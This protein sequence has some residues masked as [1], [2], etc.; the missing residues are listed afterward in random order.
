M[1]FGHVGFLEAIGLLRVLARPLRDLRAG[2]GAGLA[3]HFAAAAEQDQ[4]GML[5]MP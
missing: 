5:R 1:R 2:H 3:R 4:R